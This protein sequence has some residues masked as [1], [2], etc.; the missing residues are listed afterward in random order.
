[1]SSPFPAGSQNPF[2][3]DSLPE[4]TPVPYAQPMQSAQFQNAIYQQ[5]G[6]LILHKLA[7]LPDRC[8]KSN[9]PTT[10]RLKRTLY[11]HHPA[12]YLVIL[13]NLIIYA[14]VAMAV[15][16]SAVLQI[17]LSKEYKQRRIRNMLIAWGL[18]LLGILSMVIGIIIVD[19]NE[20]GFL[21]FILFPI[22]LLIG[23]LWGIYGC[24]VIYAKKIDDHYV[25]V[26]GVS[27]EFL[28]DFPVWPYH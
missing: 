27:P 3:V 17:P 15:R 22:L 9:E 8:I 26:K 14:V 1:M 21:G 13:L 6:V 16:K 11:W 5:N 20:L 19:S 12:I 23:A 28:R 24:R 10:E 2:A 4:Q 18:V 7:I 25:W